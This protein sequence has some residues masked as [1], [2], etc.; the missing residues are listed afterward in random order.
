MKEFLST[1][2]HRRQPQP[3]ISLCFLSP[4]F[5]RSLQGEAGMGWM[6]MFSTCSSS[7]GV[8]SEFQTVPCFHRAFWAHQ[9]VPVRH[10]RSNWPHRT[11]SGEN[12]SF[13]CVYNQRNL[14][15]INVQYPWGRVGG[16]GEEKENKQKLDPRSFHAVLKANK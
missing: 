14:S 16:G 8:I 15:L 12:P 2:F 6:R 9:G 7:Q 4:R 3:E 1:S 13:L 11:C 5:S 10:V